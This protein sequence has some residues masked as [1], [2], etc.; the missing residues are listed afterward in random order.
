[1]H[2][3]QRFTLTIEAEPRNVPGIIRLRKLLKRLLRAYGFVCTEIRPGANNQTTVRIIGR[4]NHPKSS[5]HSIQDSVL[6]K[7]QPLEYIRVVTKPT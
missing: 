5:Q 4:D 2:E 1:M 6:A 7:P 3:Q